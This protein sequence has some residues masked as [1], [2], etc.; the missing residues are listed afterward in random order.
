MLSTQHSPTPVRPGAGGSGRRSFPKCKASVSLSSPEKLSSS[1]SSQ[2]SSGGGICCKGTPRHWAAWALCSHIQT[3]WAR[4]LQKPHTQPER[5]LSF[6]QRGLAPAA[7]RLLANLTS[8]LPRSFATIQSGVLPGRGSNQLTLGP[9]CYGQGHGA[10][11]RLLA[12]AAIRS[13]EQTDLGH[14]PP[15]WVGRT[16]HL[17]GTR[18]IMASSR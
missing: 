5:W 17:P 10:V 15:T 16:T 12:A 11:G 3:L 1:P 6:T 18:S 9:A 8:Q 14:W 4:D 7:R 2:S 13:Q